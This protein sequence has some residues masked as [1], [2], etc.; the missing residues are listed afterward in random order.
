[1]RNTLKPRL[2]GT[3]VLLFGDVPRISDFGVAIGAD[4]ANLMHAGDPRLHIA[5]I[6]LRSTTH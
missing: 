5:A 2:R 3:N 1:V 4:L 6:E